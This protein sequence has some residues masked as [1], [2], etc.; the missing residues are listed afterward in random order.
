MGIREDSSE[1]STDV[2]CQAVDAGQHNLCGALE[3][4]IAT[5]DQVGMDFRGFNKL[6][7]AR[8][9]ALEAIA[10]RDFGRSATFLLVAD[11]LAQGT[12][13]GL[14]VNEESH[15]AA[16]ADGLKV[17]RENAFDDDDGVRLE[18]PIECSKDSRNFD[19]V[20]MIDIEVPY[21]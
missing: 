12:D 9:G 1:N 4:G 21:F 18:G 8:S 3:V 14:E 16:F 5:H 13:I 10:G 7:V 20:W 19:C 6:V 2:L 11:D 15:I 17:Q